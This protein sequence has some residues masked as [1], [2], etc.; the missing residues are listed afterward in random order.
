MEK[1]MLKKFTTGQ[2]F[3]KKAPTFDSFLK[4]A[5]DLS[6]PHTISQGK[7]NDATGF[8]RNPKKIVM[9][10]RFKTIGVGQVFINENKTKVQYRLPEDTS[11]S[12]YKE[13]YKNEIES[14]ISE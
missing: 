2:S 4:T 13:K 3:A 12:E 14:F 7:N 6:E 9:E 10:G 11:L 8:D 1:N 5:K